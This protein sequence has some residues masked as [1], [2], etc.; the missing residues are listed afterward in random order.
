LASKRVIIAHPDPNACGRLASRLYR[1]GLFSVD[2][3]QDGFEVAAKL[4][5]NSY[6][7][8]ILHSQ[9]PGLQPLRAVNQVR[10]VPGMVRMPIL[11]LCAESDPSAL[12]TLRSMGETYLLVE[13]FDPN[14]LAET[15]VRLTRGRGRRRG[16]RDASGVPQAPGGQ[17][18]LAPRPDAQP[19][20][21]PEPDVFSSGAEESAGFVPGAVE[22]DAF[23]S[24]EAH[25][26][27][28]AAVA[29]EPAAAQ[30]SAAANEAVRAGDGIPASETAAAAVASPEVGPI[31]AGPPADAVPS[32]PLQ[33]AGP[34]A[35][36]AGADDPAV[37]PRRR[38]PPE[39][40]HEPSTNVGMGLTDVIWY[41][42]ERGAP[43]PGLPPG[44]SRLDDLVSGRMGDVLSKDIIGIDQSLAVA[45]LKQ[46]NSAEFSGMEKVA[47]L[48][49][50]ML[51]VG[52]R[53]VAR[54]VIAT[55]EARSKIAPPTREFL[56]GDYWRHCL[57]VACI[58]EEIA[59]HLRYRSC[60][61]VYSA[62]LLHDVGKLFF[63]TYFREDYERV[64]ARAA[65][66]DDLF[67]GPLDISPH[68]RE[69]LKVDHGL[70]GTE[71]CR[72][73]L[74]PPVVQAGTLHHVLSTD[75]ARRLPDSLVTMIVALANLVEHTL[76]RVQEQKYAEGYAH[77]PTITDLAADMETVA[78]EVLQG[79]YKS[80]YSTVPFWVHQ[81]L[82]GKH[83]PLRQV[84]DAALRRVKRA[85]RRAGLQAYSPRWA[86]GTREDRKAG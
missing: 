86:G 74:L 62:G 2:S 18:L 84:Y 38:K 21:S 7:C 48:D 15:T 83:V 41:R 66:S 1:T 29:G 75:R 39:P 9:T 36:P 58:A 24:G 60:D 78:Q 35:P 76:R 81:F 6:D 65:E 50:A 8:L 32:N 54:H 59:Q 31:A 45:I 85:T 57:M 51:R 46:A 55:W 25:R 33:A 30:D 69:V 16:R 19:F 17:G 13:P 79:F 12:Q 44:V 34:P 5:T 68:E 27:E 14:E 82:R 52:Q 22:S 28:P 23:A 40:G 72:A 61:A 56:L 70:I 53:G 80:I 49:Q 26:A 20:G 42:A 37:E 77:D 73:W 3:A 67:G 43:I 4:Y 47:G 71:L 63:V 11:V 10:A 64:L